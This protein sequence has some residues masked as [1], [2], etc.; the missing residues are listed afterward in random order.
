MPGLLPGTVMR[1][2]FIYQQATAEEIDNSAPKS[3]MRL[4]P[5]RLTGLS[6]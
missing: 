5:Y 2:S 3:E 1:I 6:R 4:N